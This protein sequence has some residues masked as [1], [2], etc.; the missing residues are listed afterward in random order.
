MSH[1]R[2]SRL[3]VAL[4]C[5]PALLATSCAPMQTSRAVI[6]NELQAFL[7]ALFAPTPDARPGNA[8]SELTPVALFAPP[9]GQSSSAAGTGL[10]SLG[11]AATIHDETEVVTGETSVVV[12]ARVGAYKRIVTHD[13]DGPRIDA[14]TAIL[15]RELDPRLPRGTEIIAVYD[16][17]HSRVG[18]QPRLLALQIGS[19]TNAKRALRVSDAA[20]DVDGFYTPEGRV[21]EARFLRYPL[22]FM[23]VTSP[24]SHRRRHPIL[25]RSRPH[26]GVDLAAPYGTPVMAVADGNVIEADVAGNYGRAVAIRHDGEYATGYAHLASI[27]PGIAPGSRVRKGDIIG[28]VG[29]SGLTTGPHLHFSMVR[30]DTLID[31]LAAQLPQGAPLDRTLLRTLRTA[32]A[33]FSKTFARAEAGRE[34]PTRVAARSRR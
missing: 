15:A 28:F 8:D 24:F 13:E 18:E 31:P 14:R 16:T 34:Q 25:K 5:V 7:P 21:L 10:S 11:S 32:A 19:G 3:H 4:L 9:A 29:R 22:D 27:A 2:S 23:L 17:S 30:G 1:D 20:L 26:L 6:A 12:R 33:Q